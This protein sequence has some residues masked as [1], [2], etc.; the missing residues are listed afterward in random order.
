MIPDLR[1]MGKILDAQDLF[2]DH[3]IPTVVLKT[4]MIDPETGGRLTT[5]IRRKADQL[6][7]LP[8]K[9]E[10]IAA[11]QFYESPVELVHQFATRQM[12]RAR[13]TYAV[14]EQPVTVENQAQRTAGYFEAMRDIRALIEEM[15]KELQTR[16]CAGSWYVA[17]DEDGQLTLFDERPEL[18][19]MVMD[20]IWWSKTGKERIALPRHYMP[21]LS[22][23]TCRPCHVTVELIPGRNNGSAESK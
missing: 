23:K 9:M 22:V 10:E 13:S 12:D 4:V 11:A 6:D 3:G 17:R 20:K 18:K 2:E 15:M 5:L 8:E 21:E 1:R 16:S 19:E 7:T 14:T